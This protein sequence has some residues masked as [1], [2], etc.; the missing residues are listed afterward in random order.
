MSF[1]NNKC[2]WLLTP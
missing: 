2:F 1:K